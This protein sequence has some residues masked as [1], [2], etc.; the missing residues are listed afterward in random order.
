[1]IS[2]PDLKSYSEKNNIMGPFSEHNV[3]RNTSFDLTAI[4]IDCYSS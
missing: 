3:S 4:V 1:M 2:V